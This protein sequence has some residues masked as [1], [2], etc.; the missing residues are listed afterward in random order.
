VYVSAQQR[1]IRRIVLPFFGER[2]D[3]GGFERWQCTFLGDDAFPLVRIRNHH[4]ECALTQSG[5]HQDR[6]DERWD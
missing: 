2:L 3:V 6:I 5:A 1:S 4:A